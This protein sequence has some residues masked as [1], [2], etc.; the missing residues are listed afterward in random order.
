MSLNAVLSANLKRLCQGEASIAA[1]CRG[2]GINR[3]QF[4]RYLS[5]ENVPN[6]RNLEKICRYFRIDEP[7]LFREQGDEQADARTP[8]ES[9]WSLVDVRSILKSLHSETVASIP[10]GNYFANFAIPHDRDTVMRST[11]VIRN[12]GNLTTFRRLTGHSEPRE[13]WWSHFNGDHAGAVLE[14]RGWLYFV[15]LN[16]NGNREPSLLILRWLTNSRAMLAGTAT[17]M[18]PTG[19]AVTAV[20]I[21][22]CPAGTGLRSALKASHVYSTDDPTIE[23]MVLDAIEQQSQSLVS[24]ASSRVDLTVRPL[25]HPIH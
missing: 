12:D 8:G 2:T 4:N 15:G 14:R 18:T 13:S 25:H 10:A 23:P 6:K 19:P 1:V 24:M 22:P 16:R 21:H 7:Q 17:V 20:A 11:L 5:G 9:P 3:Q